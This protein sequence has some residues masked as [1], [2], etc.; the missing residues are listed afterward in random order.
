MYIFT[1]CSVKLL[2]QFNGSH[3]V[4]LLS[5]F[6]GSHAV[7]PKTKKGI[8]CYLVIKNLNDKVNVQ[9]IK[10]INIDDTS[11][12]MAELLTIKYILSLMDQEYNNTKIPM[13]LYTDCENFVNLI[14]TRKYNKKL[15]KHKNFPLYEE[16]LQLTDRLNIKIIW[17]KDPCKKNTKELHEMIFSQVDRYAKYKLKNSKKLLID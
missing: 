12:T 1:H 17:M 8:G 7:N 6:N 2:S 4:K 13:Y 14:R 11:S 5:Q 16:L 3:A 10:T 9:D 15:L